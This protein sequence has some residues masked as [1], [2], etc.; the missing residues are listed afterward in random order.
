MFSW[1]VPGKAGR[2]KM[3]RALRSGAWVVRWVD[4]EVRFWERMEKRDVREDLG[5]V[6]VMMRVAGV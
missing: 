2:G 1:A 6:S 5:C 3:E 4:R